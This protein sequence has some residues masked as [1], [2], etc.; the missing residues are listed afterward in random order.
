MTIDYLAKQALEHPH[1]V[2]AGI[3]WA[4]EVQRIRM[5]LARRTADVRTM[6]DGND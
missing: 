4:L 1:G 5:E 2:E 6:S 3:R